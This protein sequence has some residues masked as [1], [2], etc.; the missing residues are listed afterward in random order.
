M[1]L[2][3][4]LALAARSPAQDSAGDKHQIMAGRWTITTVGEWGKF[5]EASAFNQ[6]F[7]ITYKPDTQSFEGRPFGWPIT[8]TSGLSAKAGGRVSFKTEY[9]MGP[10]TYEIRWS[11]T[12]NADGTAIENGSFTT[13]VSKGTFTAQKLPADAPQD[14]PRSG[15]RPRGDAAAPNAGTQP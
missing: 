7:T 4:A 3:L 8:G 10:D 5:Q 6:T 15:R 2:G 9:K 11:G 12:L 14:A 1:G 13:R